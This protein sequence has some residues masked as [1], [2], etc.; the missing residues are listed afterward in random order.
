VIDISAH[1]STP[2]TRTGERGNARA[3]ERKYAVKERGRESALYVK[4]RARRARR[5]IR[6]RIFHHY[7]PAERR[8]QE[9]KGIRMIYNDWEPTAR[10]TYK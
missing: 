5:E 6:K 2:I 10:Q 1:A 9:S 7:N 3:R 8:G 4:Q